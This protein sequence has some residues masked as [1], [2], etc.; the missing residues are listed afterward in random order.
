MAEEIKS[1]EDLGEAVNAAPA[2]DDEQ[3]AA[4]VYVLSLIHI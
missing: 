2:M 4:P 1:L 3:Q